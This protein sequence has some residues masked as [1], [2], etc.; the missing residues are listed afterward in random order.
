[1]GTVEMSINNLLNTLK[2][3]KKDI[4]TSQEFERSKLERIEESQTSKRYEERGIGDGLVDLE[5]RSDL[6]EKERLIH[7]T[8]K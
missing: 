5:V 4:G 1:M 8:P 2:D 3:V 6:E 7:T